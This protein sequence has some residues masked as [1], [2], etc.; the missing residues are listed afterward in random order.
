MADPQGLIA[1]GAHADEYEPEEQ[2]LLDAL[3]GLQTAE[4]LVANILPP[5]EVIWQKS[6][7]LSEEELAVR[8]PKLLSLAKEI[9]RFF[10]PASKPRTRGEMLGDDAS[11]TPAG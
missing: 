10:G 3:S 9:E 8:R 7:S 2:A 11:D 1:E 6:F 5:L 4:L